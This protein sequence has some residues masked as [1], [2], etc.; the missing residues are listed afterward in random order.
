MKKIQKGLIT[1][2]ISLSLIGF[3]GGLSG[4]ITYARGNGYYNNNGNHYGHHKIN[5]WNNGIGYYNRHNNMNYFMKNYNQMNAWNCGFGQNQSYQNMINGWNNGYIQNNNKKIDF[6]DLKEKVEDYIDDMEYNDEDLEIGSV[7]KKDDK[8]YVFSIVLEDSN[9]EVMKI[10]VNPYTGYMYRSNFNNGN[11]FNQTQKIALKDLKEK[12]EDY[13]D[14][15]ERGDQDLEIGNI[16]TS[17]NRNYVFTIVDEDNDDKKVMDL[18]V[19]PYTG[20]IYRN[21]VNYT[22]YMNYQGKN[23]DLEDI[24]DKIEDYIDDVERGDQDL[25]ISS[26]D[27]LNN[28]NYLFRIVDE[29]N[30]DKKV[31]DITV[32]PH[33]GYMSTN[34]SN[35]TMMNPYCNFQLQNQGEKLDLKELKDKVEDY[36]HDYDK[37]LEIDETF[38][39][40]EGYYYFSIKEDDTNRGAME[41]LVNPYT[42]NIY[43][44]PG[45][46]V[47]WNQKY[48]MKYNNTYVGSGNSKIKEDYRSDFRKNKISE[49]EALKKARDYVERYISKEY[50]VP[51]NGEEYYGYYAFEIENGNKRVGMIN[52]NGVTGEVWCTR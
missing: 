31:M 12:I 44:K 19:N 40:D 45:P 22:N 48:N 2:G 13:I 16:N 7:N 39:Y 17:N 32:N 15:I 37:D 51:S 52:I 38:K 14:D 27:S 20:Y 25:E 41:L 26:I 4:D 43:P 36:I 30:N 50:D 11:I 24:K 9:R 34:N 46:N 18:N 6:D 42:G 10:N 8:N 5:S 35:Y 21:N 23:L 29:D 1:F 28:G 3:V 49:K 47:M 33:T